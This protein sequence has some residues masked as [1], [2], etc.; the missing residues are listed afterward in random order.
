V[1]AA[2]REDPAGLQV[3][4]P[5][6]PP[7]TDLAGEAKLI[8]AQTNKDKL[9][10]KASQDQQTNLQKQ[11]EMKQEQDIHATDVAKEVIIHQADQQKIAADREDAQAKVDVQRLQIER[12]HEREQMG[13]GLEMVKAGLGAH[14]AN[15]SH[16][17]DVQSHKLEVANHVLDAKTAAHEAMLGTHEALNPREPAKPTSKPKGKK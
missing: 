15:Q 5:A 9:A 7:P 13:H 10:Q 14:E 6:A 17:L 1:L 16:H 11:A 12:Q 4:A 3:Q 8:E 2:M